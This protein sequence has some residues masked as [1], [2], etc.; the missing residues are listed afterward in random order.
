M[1]ELPRVLVPVVTPFT[2]DAT[3]L[4]EIRMARLLRWYLDAGV[5]G[6]VT[7]TDAGEFMTTSFD[8]RKKTLEFCIRE[9]Q[10]RAVVLAHVSTLSTA[11]SLDLAQHAARHGARAVVLMPPY[12]GALS[13]DEIFHHVHMV[14][15]HG[16]LDVLVVDPQAR[17]ASPLVASLRGIPHVTISSP[18]AAGLRSTPT[19]WPSEFAIGSATCLPLAA[20]LPEAAEE[21]VRSGTLPNGWQTVFSAQGP[22]RVL[23]TALAMLD[24]EV[25]PL[26]TPYSRVPDDIRRN[27][28]TLLGV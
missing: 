24:R 28:I 26:R 7:S 5:G 22:T 19:Q 10:G 12:Y 25:G 20:I 13:D 4:S 27:L 18:L 14:A 1:V 17:L 9:A 3:T 8:E 6:F 21:I 11:A 16:G 15:Q 23:K 2:D